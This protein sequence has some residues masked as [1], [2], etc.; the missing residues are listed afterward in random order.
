MRHAEPRVILVPFQLIVPFIVAHCQ[1][2]KSP[3]SRACGTWVIP[4]SVSALNC[5]QQPSLTLSIMI[6][7]DN[8]QIPIPKYPLTILTPPPFRTPTAEVLKVLE[9]RVWGLVS[10]DHVWSVTFSPILCPEGK[11]WLFTLKPYYWEKDGK[12]GE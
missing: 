2:F 4:A 8:R 12:W 9:R 6:V 3:L 5:F 10:S 1:P 11:N 7:C